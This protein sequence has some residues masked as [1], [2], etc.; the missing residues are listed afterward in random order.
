MGQKE[1]P[2]QDLTGF[3][4]MTDD[5]PLQ[6]KL[7]NVLGVVNEPRHWQTMVDG[8]SPVRDLGLGKV[9]IRSTP[10]RKSSTERHCTLVVTVGR[11][12]SK[13][14]KNILLV[15]KPDGF[16]DDRRQFETAMR[17]K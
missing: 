10:K 3:D 14:L 4:P 7:E 13:L 17:P 12:S 6:Q 11:F 8:P 16:I 9:G 5:G 1:T 2:G 15:R